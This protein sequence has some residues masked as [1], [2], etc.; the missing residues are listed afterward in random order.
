MSV[1]EDNKVGMYCH[2]LVIDHLNLHNQLNATGILSK[3]TL[4]LLT[5]IVD[6]DMA[7]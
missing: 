5:E 3:L 7:N 4:F 6:M 2:Y 1:T